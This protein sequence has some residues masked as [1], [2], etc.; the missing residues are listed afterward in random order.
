MITRL[1]FIAAAL[2]PTLGSQALKF[3]VASVKPDSSTIGRGVPVMDAQRLVWHGAT[4]KHMICEAYQL[5]YAQVTGAPSWTDTE[6]YDVEARAERPS[7]RDQLRQMLRSLLSDRFRLATQ[8]QR[9]PLPAYALTVAKGG[10]KFKEVPAEQENNPNTAA[11]LNQFS[12]RSSMPQLAGMLSQ[13]MSGPIFNGYTGRLE[14]RED[15]PAMVIDQTGLKGIYEINLNLNG[16][17]DGDFA[18]ALQSA[19][20]AVGLSL[21]EKR[22]QVEVLFVVRAERIPTAN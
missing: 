18:S 17:A 4:L 12:R 16:P 8:M 15:R 1:L 20:A 19:L 3:E 22:M 21:D 7:T 9:K 13:M 5:Q 6:R 10:T 14:P 2:L 11:R